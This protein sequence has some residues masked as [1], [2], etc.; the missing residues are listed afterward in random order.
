MEHS[1]LPVPIVDC[2]NLVELC[3]AVHR[4]REAQPCLVEEWASEAA[5]GEPLWCWSL[6]PAVSQRPH[7]PSSMSRSTS[8]PM[9]ISELSAW[10]FPA[11]SKLDGDITAR[12]T[13]LRTP[14]SGPGARP[15]P[16]TSTL[17][18][19]TLLASMPLPALSR[20]AR[21][22]SQPT[23][24]ITPYSGPGARPAPSTSIPADLRIPLL[25]EC[26]AVSK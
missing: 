2:D 3:K 6:S 7:P 11:V 14:Y 9:G 8:L 10:A 22:A 21:A 26:P 5:R 24:L 25:S 15:A 20:S 17:T 19:F 16:S 12:R 18:G 13:C 23:G 1:L 4:S